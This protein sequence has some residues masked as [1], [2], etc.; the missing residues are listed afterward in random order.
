MYSIRT[1]YKITYETAKLHG[2]ETRH[3]SVEI[4]GCGELGLLRVEPGD[5][6]QRLADARVIGV[7]R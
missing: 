4:L 7:E 1:V 5:L 3:L 2:T 6:V